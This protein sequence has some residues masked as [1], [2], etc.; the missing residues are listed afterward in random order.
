MSLKT[1]RR[2]CPAKHGRPLGAPDGARNRTTPLL[3]GLPED[4]VDLLDEAEELP[5]LRRVLRLLRVAGGLRGLPEEVVELGVR[6]EV[7][8]LEVVGPQDPQMVLHQVRPLL[9]DEEAPGLEVLDRLGG[10]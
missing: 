10:L 9:R 8:G 4:R 1:D 2:A 7:L 3:L 5:A 6:L